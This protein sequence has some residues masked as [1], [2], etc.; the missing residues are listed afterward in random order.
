[1]E[2][3]HEALRVTPG[4][5]QARLVEIRVGLRPVSADGLPII[6]NLAHS[7]GVT[8]VTGHGPNGLQLVPYSGK[9]V[10]QLALEQKPDMEM[11]AFEL[12]R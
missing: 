6:S 2:V 8:I 11:K 3:L 1:M 9:L 7:P 4:L 5:A 12:V 10:A